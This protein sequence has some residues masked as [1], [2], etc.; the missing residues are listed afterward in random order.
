MGLWFSYFYVLQDKNIRNFKKQQPKT[1]VQV[2]DAAVHET[3]LICDETAAA[4]DSHKYKHYFEFIGSTTKFLN[5]KICTLIKF[6][7]KPWATYF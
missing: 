3:S 2:D 5:G 4:F 6:L 7:S 1:T